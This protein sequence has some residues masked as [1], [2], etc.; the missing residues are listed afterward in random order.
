MSQVEHVLDMLKQ[1]IYRRANIAK[2]VIELHEA[3]LEEWDNIPQRC[4]ASHVHSMGR[5]CSWLLELDT[6]D[7]NTVK[8]CVDHVLSSILKAIQSLCNFN[9]VYQHCLF[10]DRTTHISSAVMMLKLGKMKS[11]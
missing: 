3:L 8:A 1:R 7:S 6:L 4:S 9:F 5:I 2:N 10:N 11:V